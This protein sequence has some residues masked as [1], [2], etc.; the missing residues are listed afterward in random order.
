[1]PVLNTQQA[2][3][4]AI[5][6]ALVAD[7]FSKAIV[8]MYAYRL[9]DGLPVFPGFNLTFL[10][11]D[12]VTFGLFG[13]VPWWTLT[14]IAFVVCGLIA[15]ML[16]R[17][18]QRHEAVA[19]GLII[20]GAVGNIIDRLRFAAVTDFLDFYVG[21][22]HWPAF[23]IA[24]VTIVTGVALLFVAGTVKPSTAT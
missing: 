4:I 5:C 24:D 15:M 10:R 20:G 22:T 7:Q 19:Y 11:N 14:I 17:T 3:L 9:S 6:A 23:N 16:W 8:A 21:N 1:M 12:G 2:G 13:D 18:T